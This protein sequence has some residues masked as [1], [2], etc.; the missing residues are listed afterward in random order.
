MN[1]VARAGCEEVAM[2]YLAALRDEKYVEF[3]H[4]VQPP[5]PVEKKWVLIISTL[6]GCPAG[7]PIC[8][9][10]GW[11]EGKLTTEEL[12]AQ[13]DYMV[14]SK[15]PDGKIPVE[16]FKIQFARMGEPSF[17]P[18]VLD[19]L[20][21]FSERYDAPGF[22]PSVSTI[23]PSGCDK[24]MSELTE[25][26]NSLYGNGNFQMQFSLHSTS[27]EEREKLIPVKK[28]DLKKISEFGNQFF[29]EGDRK[30]TLN[31]ALA[32]NSSLNPDVI[33][34]TFDPSKF[35]VKVTPVNPT[36]KCEENGITSRVQG[37]HS[38]EDHPF[39]AEL[40]NRG[41][42][43]ILSIGEL[44]ENKIGSNCGQYIKSFLANKDSISAEGAYE[45]RI[46][47]CTNAS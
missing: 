38:E 22:M 30:I 14:R 42:D 28:W 27:D 11:Y 34:D 35:L 46:E 16:K 3:V 19:V 10:G 18:A 32:E 41:F 5:Y 24:F 15:F 12:Y 40:R 37:N 39:I 4:S 25:I 8:D 29:R 13:I 45:Y 36:M 20:R 17:N 26:K 23:A 33:S 9:A 43:V 6:F 44:E 31:F 21:T 47:T 2:V 7:C 1:I